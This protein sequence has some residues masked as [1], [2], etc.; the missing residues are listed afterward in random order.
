MVC[1]SLLH[2]DLWPIKVQ[3]SLRLTNCPKQVGY[4]FL[5]VGERRR[6]GD[7]ERGDMRDT[8]G[9]CSCT[10]THTHARQLWHMQL[11]FHNRFGMLHNFLAPWNV[12][13]HKP[14]EKDGGVHSS[15]TQHLIFHRAGIIHL[16][17]LL[18][19][20]FSQSVLHAVERSCDRLLSWALL[21]THFS[22]V[23]T[24]LIWVNCSSGVCVYMCECEWLSKLPLPF[25]QSSLIVLHCFEIMI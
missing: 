20:V 13:I 11:K 4:G 6:T 1:V 25:P 5:W 7:K 8:W 2:Y 19:S 9:I 12:I 24:S 22:C 10:D 18:K 23:F 17:V 21:D 14:G 3:E 15:Y 16:I